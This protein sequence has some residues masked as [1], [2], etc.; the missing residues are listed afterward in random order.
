MLGVFGVQQ[1]V[2]VLGRPAVFG[3][4]AVIVG[5]DDLVQEALAPED[6][7]QQ[8]LAVMHFAVVDVEVQ[9]AVSV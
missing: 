7:I 9:A 8:D 2:V 1:D 4:A 3:P 5:P 6:G